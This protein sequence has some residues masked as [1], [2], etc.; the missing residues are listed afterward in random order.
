M[1][2]TRLFKYLNNFLSVAEELYS[3]ITDSRYKKKKIVKGVNEF[4]EM[5]YKTPP[6]DI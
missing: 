4:Q 1:A 2:A 3:E 5:K 6:R